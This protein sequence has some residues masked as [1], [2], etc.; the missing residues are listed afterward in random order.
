MQLK[1][2]PFCAVQEVQCKEVGLGSL[3]T[4]EFVEHLSNKIARICSW[5][6]LLCGAG[7]YEVLR[8]SSCLV[9]WDKFDPVAPKEVD[10]VLCAVSATTCPL[11]PCSSWLKA[12]RW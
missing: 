5:L 4:E 3:T 10:R 8:E 12:S 6:E 9:I 11:D 2:H 1:P 7:S